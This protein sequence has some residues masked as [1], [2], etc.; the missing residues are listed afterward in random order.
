MLVKALHYF[1]AGF[2]FKLSFFRL[3]G[4]QNTQMLTEVKDS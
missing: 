1:S 3:A 2:H 4:S